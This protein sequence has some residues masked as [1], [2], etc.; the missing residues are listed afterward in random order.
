MRQS[1]LFEGVDELERAIREK[2]DPDERNLA[3]AWF[4]KN[5]VLTKDPEQ[6]IEVADLFDQVVGPSLD[7]LLNAVARYEQEMRVVQAAKRSLQTQAEIAEA[8]LREV[9][10]GVRVLESGIE[11]FLDQGDVSDAALS[12]ACDQAQ[13]RL[14]AI[15]VGLEQSQDAAAAQL[16]QWDRII[17]TGHKLE[18]DK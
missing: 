16:E 10:A 7:Q 5:H 11:D 14:D 17:E 9:G 18:E 2:S 3:L 15:A 12:A 6:V 1:G 4:Y 8:S 13:G